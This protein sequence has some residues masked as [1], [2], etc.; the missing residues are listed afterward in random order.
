[1]KKIIEEAR[2]LPVIYEGYDIAVV[3]GGIAGVAAAMAAGRAGKKVLLLE[4]MFTLG[5]LA[6][7][8]LVTIYLPLCDGNG[9]QVSFGLAEELF[10]LSISKGWETS[11]PDTWMKEGKEHGKQRFE[12][13]YNA[14]VF[15]ILMEQALVEAGVEILY[16]TTLCHVARNGNRVEALI[17]ENKD[18]RSAIPVRGVVD[19]SGDADV[20]YLAGVPTALHQVG[21]K[22][23]A[24][25]YE[26]LDG[27]TK[28]H[29]VG[30][31]DVPSESSENGA[32][33]QVKEGRITGVDARELSKWLLEGHA[34]SLE[35]FLSKGD[36]SEEHSFAT[37]A[38]MPQLRMTRKIVG[39]Y[40]LDECEAHKYFDDSIGMTGDWRKRGPIFEIPMR[41]LYCEELV[42]VTAAGRCISVTD[43]MWDIT[44][45]IPAGAVTGQAAGL[46]LAVCED[47]SKIDVEELQK[48]LRAQNV[49]LHVE[50]II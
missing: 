19:A 21:N 17:V 48:A 45:V 41:S 43:D 11:Y 2:E 5:G 7:L 33:D 15:A 9:H 36:V 37:M 31:S 10:R 8:G 24:W 35:K 1:M 16:G 42:N 50:E 38:T 23:A 39:K 32:P 28:L 6:T 14:Q 29:M 34:L 22:M 18:G 40:T 30:A 25:Y 47:T 44:R 27:S 13:R 4:R 3:G 12:V 20:F 49:K 26:T 46:M